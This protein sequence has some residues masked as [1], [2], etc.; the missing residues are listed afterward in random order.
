MDADLAG[1]G[2]NKGV[3]KSLL[4]MAGGFAMIAFGIVAATATKLADPDAW[5]NEVLAIGHVALLG[6]IGSGI[7]GD[8]W[9]SLKTAWA[10][11]E[12]GSNKKRLTTARRA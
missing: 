7:L 9:Q 3:I 4:T 10:D 5:Q 1:A 2:M 12:Q 11:A 6:V 8:G